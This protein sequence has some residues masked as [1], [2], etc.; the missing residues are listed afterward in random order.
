MALYYAICPKTGK[1]VGN[2][3]N[4]EPY[5]TAKGKNARQ[6]ELD[7]EHKVFLKQQREEKREAYRLRNIQSA[8]RNGGLQKRLNNI[9]KSAHP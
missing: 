5:K 3:K 8:M 2:K 9:F 7:A 6:A 4:G 1:L